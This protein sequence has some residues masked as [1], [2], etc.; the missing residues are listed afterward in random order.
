M[1][2]LICCFSCS[3]ETNDAR[4]RDWPCRMENQPSIWLSQEARGGVMSGGV[5][6]SHVR[7]APQPIRLAGVE[8]VGDDLDLPAGIISDNFVHESKELPAAPA[9]LA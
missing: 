6:K 3:T 5:M 1:Q 9:L 2:A 7:T 4:A 8:I